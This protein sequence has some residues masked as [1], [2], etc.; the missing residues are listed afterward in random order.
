MAYK[1]LDY[2]GLEHVIN[3]IKSKFVQRVAGKALSTNDFTDS[4]K[5][6]LDSVE[7]N[8][9]VNTVNKVND[10]TGDVVLNSEDIAF[11]SSV[12]GSTPTT[13]RKIID[14]ILVKDAEQD[15]IDSQTISRVSNLETNKADKSYT[16]TELG[17]KADKTTTYTKTEIDGKLDSIDSGVISVNEKTGVVTLD[18]DDISDTETN[19]KFVSTTEKSAWT[20]KQ[21]KLTAGSNISIV[22]NEISATDTTYP[23]ATQTVQGLISAADKKK[24]DGIATGAQVNTVNSV[25]TQTGAVVLNADDISDTET[26]NKFVSTSEKTAWNSKADVSYVDT[27][28]GRKVDKV[29]G[30]ALSAND[31]TDTLKNKLDGIATGAQTNVIEM[32]QKNGTNLSIT[33]KTVNISVPTKISDLTNDKTFKTEAEIKSLISEHG[34]L[35]KEVVLELP[36]IAAADENTMYLIR[37]EQ[38]TGYQEWMIINEVWEILGDTAAIDFTGYVHEDDI[39]LISIGEIDAMFAMA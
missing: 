22:N 10:K 28:V 1:F 5:T 31:F 32:I 9:Q 4:Y 6:K 36:T 12:A 30:K 26:D 27:G 35:K 38:D 20:N 34:K 11:T 3:T 13:T 39:S 33:E 23:A 14:D 15:L 16:D 8:A 24:L 19:N 18:A 37:N 7:T 2:E 29:T 25:N 21:D 17:K